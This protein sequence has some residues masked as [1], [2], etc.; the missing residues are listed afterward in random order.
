MPRDVVERIAV[1][2]SVEHA[3]DAGHLRVCLQLFAQLGKA[4]LA[5]EL[6][7]DLAEH[8]G[9]EPGL[10]RRAGDGIARLGMGLAERRHRLFSDSRIDAELAGDAADIEISAKLA[11]YAVQQTH[12]ATP[13]R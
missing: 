7:D 11:K 4:A 9:V 2:V 3:E 6:L 1:A 12:D 10:G 8:A 13:W 5:A